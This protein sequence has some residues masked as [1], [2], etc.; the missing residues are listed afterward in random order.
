M[1]VL[2][3]AFD[4]N[5]DNPYLPERHG[6]L[7]VVYTGTHDNDTTLGW[8]RTLDDASRR[9]ALA[10]LL[11]PR[12]ADAVGAGPRGVP[13]HRPAGRGPRPGPAR[14]RL[15]GADEHPRHGGGQLDL[16]GARRCVPRRA[17]RSR[18]RLR[19]LTDNTGRNIRDQLTIRRPELMPFG[20]RPPTVCAWTTRRAPRGRPR[21]SLLL[22]EPAPRTLRST[23][24]TRALPVPER[25][26]GAS[27]AAPISQEVLESLVEAHVAMDAHGVVVGWNHEAQLLLGWTREEALGREAAELFIPE[28][29]RERHRAGLERVRVTGRSTMAGKR[30]ELAAVDRAGRRF[31]VE[32]TIR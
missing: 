13:L 22:P 11:A 28:E 16:A 29:F 15:G 3:F 8:W 14:A 12:G 19:T 1:K 31:P 32:L 17:A 21:P 2:Q 23:R 4:G 27:V 10:H 25:R 5:D 24:H 18:A 30:L 6:E 7:S 20:A 9:R 26:A